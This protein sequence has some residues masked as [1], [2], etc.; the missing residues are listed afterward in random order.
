MAAPFAVR[1]LPGAPVSV[2]LD[3]SELD[4]FVP[5]RHTV[6]SIAERLATPDPWAGLEEAASRLDQAGARL[7]GLS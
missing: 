3:W 5:G 1:A 6:G 7:T 2:P 4:D